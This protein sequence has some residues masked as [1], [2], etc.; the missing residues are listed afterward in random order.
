LIR[1]VFI[2]TDLSTGG[3]EMMLFKVLERLDRQRFSAHVI[4]LST[5]GELAPRI[6]ALGI[7]VVTVGMEPGLP[8]PSSFIRLVKML[9]HLRP[10]VV[11]TWM[12][13]ADLLG[14]QHQASND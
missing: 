1:I 8:S 6:E 10:D 9:S 13:H 3:A 14:G 7:P 2:I 11:H 4:S 12:Y 5:S